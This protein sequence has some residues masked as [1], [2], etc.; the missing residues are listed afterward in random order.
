[1]EPITIISGVLSVIATATD[2]GIRTYE[3][4]DGIKSAPDHINRLAVVLRGLYHVLCVLSQALENVAQRRPRQGANDDLSLHMVASMKE[5]VENCIHVF[6]DV[7]KAVQPYVAA[8]GRA[9]RSFS[10]GFRWEMGKKTSVAELQKAP[11]QQQGYA[12]AG[13]LDAKLVGSLARRLAS[14]LM[15][16][17]FNSSQ[18]V[19]M[20]QHLQLDVRRLHCQL[21]DTG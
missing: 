5:L 13:H 3:L 17:S 18:T 14:W 10:K 12:R 9:F 16:S 11:G 21:D 2:L 4:V 20:V 19:E 7:D 8:N 1:M 6:Q 15:A